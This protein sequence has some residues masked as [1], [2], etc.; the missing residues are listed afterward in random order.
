MIVKLSEQ[1]IKK[2]N[3]YIWRFFI[4]CFALLIILIGLAAF[5]VFG[6][7]PS[8]HDLEN[9]KSDQATYVY[10]SDNI[11]GTRN[12]QILGKYW[13]TA[14]RS[15]VTFK[16]ISPNAIN[17]LVATED[18]HFYSHSGIDFG[19]SFT[20]ILYGMIGKR[21][22]ASTITQQLAKNQFA[23]EKPATNAINRI[24]QKLR[25]LIIAIRIEK[26]YTKQEILTMYLNTVDF[27][28][29]TAGIQSAAQTY[30]NTTA[31]K[32][33][34]EQAATLIALLKAPTQ[35][36]PIKHPKA[37]KKRRD[38]ILGRM[39]SEGFLTEG[40]ANEC[41][42][43][44]LDIDFHPINHFEGP[45]P[46]FRA[47]L[48]D[49]V[50]KILRDNSIL[51]PDGTKYDLDRDG[52]KI[53]TTINSRMQDYAEQAQR[54]YMHDLQNQFSAEWKGVSMAKRTSNYDL[55][56]NSGIQQSDRY[57]SLKLQGET[58]E[59]IKQN[60]YTP[61]T[62]DLFTWHGDV[63]TL[64]RPIDSVLY[65]KMLLHNSLMSMDPTTGY[66]KAWVGGINFEHF[67]YDQVKVGTRQVG[68]TAKPF[69]YAVA[70]EN[71]YSPCYQVNNVPISI[72]G[73][74]PRS[75]P[76]ETLPGMI[77]LR[78]AL[79]HSQN[80]VTAFVMD[81]V[82]PPLVVE[83]IKNM[84]ITTE[85]DPFPSIC[86]GVFNASVY[87]MTGA[88]SAFVNHGL[89]TEPTFLLRIEDKNGNVI[90]NSS[91]KRKQAM[92]E[93]YAY[94]MVDMLRSVVD[95]DNKATGNRLRWKYN[96]TNPIAGKTGTTSDNSDGWF[97]GAVPQLVTG[98]WTGCEDHDFHF[99]STHTGEGA[100]SALPIFALYLKKVYAD[101]SL[102]IKKD[103]NFE[104]P[105]KPL[106]TELDCSKYTQQQKGINEVEKK[107]SF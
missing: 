45:A 43:K 35:Y 6:A 36:S 46:Y 34:P 88:Y 66:I 5:G 50:K 106:T 98:I 18:N 48:K 93:E 4:G 22:G 11:P 70:I 10:A 51:K 78:S 75:D 105:K 16:Q 30:F 49:E 13:H 42:E 39:A 12:L 67:K 21:Q 107:L 44:S 79:A 8:L 61:D 56:I 17:A 96:F 90:Y 85:V 32:L 52:L 84:G 59:E 63:D 33:T 15:N 100:N 37:S 53:Y 81:T 94:V 47:V 41:M 27:G 29:N 57:K 104:L 62:L 101:Q 76:K 83:L 7:L 86:L 9:P 2:Y 71:G 3:W 19:R 23:D 24:L 64:M 38:F 74:S 97:I 20:I 82:K 58:D 77:T 14:N 65:S 103:K 91:P 28:N 72:D 95:M 92:N 31:D 54:E 68:S 26:H 69:T 55:V 80:W 99:R 40:Q 60:F 25:E 73:W 87:D 1:D 89:W 102:G